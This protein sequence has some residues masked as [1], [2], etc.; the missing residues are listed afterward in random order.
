MKDASAS[1]WT[2]AL[3]IEGACLGV[4]LAFLSGIYALVNQQLTEPYMVRFPLFPFLSRCTSRGFHIN[5]MSLHTMYRQDE[6]FHVRQTQAY[7]RADW[8]SWDS[9]ITTLPGL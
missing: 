9:K 3:W 8:W 4:Y 7:C 5:E 2:H 6:I 1:T